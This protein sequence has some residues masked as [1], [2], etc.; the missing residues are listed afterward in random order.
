MAVLPP[1]PV[2]PR[3][4]LPW[5][6]VLAVGATVPLVAVLVVGLHR[7]PQAIPSPLIGQPA[8]AFS[9]PLFDGGAITNTTY[10]GRVVV[11]NFWASWCYPACYQEAPEL[12]RAW[13]RFQ[14]RGIMVVG[15]NIQDREQAA[16]QFIREFGQTFPNGQDSTGKISINFGVYGVPETFILD[17]QG[18]VVYKHVGAITA[19]IIADQ[20]ERYIQGARVP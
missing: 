5:A 1:P 15:I 9:L 17:P 12:Q 2:T 8:P 19:Q 4:A 13:E 11:L 7:D 18:R 10:R 6:W 14:G 16:R 20:A 3:R